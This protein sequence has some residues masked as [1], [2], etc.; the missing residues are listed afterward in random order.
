MSALLPVCAESAYP[1]STAGARVRVAAFAP[2]L[3]EHGV[4]L[5]FVSHL[6]REEYRTLSSP[7]RRLAKARVIA[8]SLVRVATRP[9]HPDGITMAHRLL[10]LVPVPGSDPPAQ[11]DVYDF[12]DALFLGLSVSTENRWLRGLKRE[13]Q[14]CRQYLR[15]A[16]LVIAGNDYLASYA[17]CHARQVEIVPSC[18]D[19]TS[20]EVRRHGD[21]EVLTVGWMGSA[22]TSIY[23]HEVLPVF[24]RINRDRIRMKLV[25]VGAVG[26]PSEP[27]IEQRPWSLESEAEELAGFDVGIMPLPDDPWT[28][29]KCGYKL[30]R[31]YAAGV[32]AVASPVGVNRELLDGGAGLGAASS[33]EWRTALEELATDVGARREAGSVGRKLVEADYS[34]QRWAPELAAMLASGGDRR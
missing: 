18:V 9:R 20:Q 23:L 29:G 26:L 6:S 17:R 10:S 22:S 19:P 21:V 11:I 24:R 31:Y 16:G 34:Y 2:F 4:D 15:S 32:P 30:L 14:R 27:W 13:S 8:R 33:D 28:R 12:D 25:A 7:G 1:T 5:S 3:R